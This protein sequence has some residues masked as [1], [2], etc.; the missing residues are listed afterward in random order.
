MPE[1]FVRHG[2]TVKQ[3]VNNESNNIGLQANQV[4]AAARIVNKAVM[5][6]LNA[7]SKLKHRVAGDTLRYAQRYF[8]FGANGPTEA[9]RQHMLG[10]LVL[11]LNGLRGE[12]TIV[13]D[14][15]AF[16]DG[17]MGWASAIEVPDVHYAGTKQQFPERKF[18]YETGTGNYRMYGELNVSD[19]LLFGA[20]KIGLVTFIHE[21]SHRYANTEDFGPEGISEDGVTFQQPGLT[22]AQA[23]LNAESYGWFAYKVGR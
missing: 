19:H 16:N 20:Q 5:C 2:V 8:R 15:H 1:F 12:K 14:R 22:V 13:V 6:V 10:V 11:T 9:Q 4:K 17:A 21:A 3:G 23:L 7:H 18:H